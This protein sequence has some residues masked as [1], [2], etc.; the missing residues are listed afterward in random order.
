MSSTPELVEPWDLRARFAAAMSSMYKA[1]VPLYADLIDIVQG[2]NRNLVAAQQLPVSV[3]SLS[4]ERH[5]AIRLGT[6]DELRVV[7]RIFKMLDMHPVGYYD[8]SIAGLPMH[9]TA[10]RPTTLNA[11]FFKSPFRVF[12]TLLRPELLRSEEAR[13][14]AKTLLARRNIFSDELMRM[15]STAD[16]QSDRFTE[17]QAAVFIREALRTFSWQSVA[18][19]TMEEYNTLKAEHPILADIAC[20]QTAHINHLTPRTLDINRVQELMQQ[21]GMKV[22]ARIEGPPH[23][24]CPILLRQ[25]SFLALEEKVSFRHD[26]HSEALVPS[27]HTA[28]FGEIEQRGAALTPTGRALYDSLLAESMHKSAGLGPEDADAV[29]QQVFAAFPDAW[30]TLRIQGLIY[31]KYTAVTTVK[32]KPELSPSSRNLLEQLIL[33]GCVEATPLTYEDFLPFSAAGIF[34]SNLG[35]AEAGGGDA[36][37]SLES[38]ANQDGLEA[39]LGVKLQDIYA[40]YEHTQQLS[41][42]GISNYYSIP[43]LELI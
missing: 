21:R 2:V 12:T 37:C 41:I 14:L 30:D 33:E 19:S 7:Q 11:G 10:F 6:A 1:E 8:L 13:V 17:E 26:G 27:S 9:A 32:H 16:S 42:E 29:A 5:G 39:A 31:C 43:V 36:D 3:E 15:L 35:P 20:F 4:A 38:V 24:N 25:T 18:A 28:R 23:R 40:W 22:K 34:R